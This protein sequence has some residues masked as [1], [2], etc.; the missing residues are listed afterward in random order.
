MSFFAFIVSHPHPVSMSSYSRTSHSRP[1][2]CFFPFLSD[3][4]Q[5]S[6]FI[7]T[8]IMSSSFPDLLFIF[9]TVS[10]NCFFVAF[11]PVGS[12]KCWVRSAERF[13][14]EN[15]SASC[16]FLFTL[17]REIKNTGFDIFS[18]NPYFFFYLSLLLYINV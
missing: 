13:I 5:I 6:V 12:A 16:D 17:G 15:F 4:P 1:A 7:S 9:S 11:H 14:G 18:C 2:L 8:I 3:I 10:P